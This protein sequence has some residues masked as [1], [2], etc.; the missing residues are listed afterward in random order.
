MDYKFSDFITK[1]KR[2]AVKHL[3]VLKKILEVSGYRT[4]NFLEENFDD[5]EPYIFCYN[6]VQDPASFEGI[7]IYKIGNEIAFRIQ[8]QDKTHPFGKAYIIP[9][10]EMF[11][12]FIEDMDE[13]KAGEEVI[14]M[15]GKEIRTFFEK[16]KKAENDIMTG[17]FAGE[18][19]LVVRSTGTDYSSL[20]YNKS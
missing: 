8:K 20:V 13:K 7:R 19:S 5:A 12:Y 2:E 4:S 14:N 16:C 11:N 3:S 17:S 15:I 9:V 1:K 6:P 18:D 10:E